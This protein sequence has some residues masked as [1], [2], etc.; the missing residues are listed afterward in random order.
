MV[1]VDGSAFIR[2]PSFTVW[3]RASSIRAMEYPGRDLTEVSAGYSA[4]RL[5][6]R[7]LFFSKVC[8]GA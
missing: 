2:W 5:P 7:F 3:G 1:G 6:L 8:Q 4:K